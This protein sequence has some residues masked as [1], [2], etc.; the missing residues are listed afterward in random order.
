MHRGKIIYFAPNS[1][2]ETFSL[3]NRYG[4]SARI[5]GGGTALF[6]LINRGLLEDVKCLVDLNNLGFK[7][8]H[9]SNDSL[10]IGAYVTMSEL[11]E[12][13]KNANV[14]GLDVLIDCIDVIRPIQ[15]RN[16]ATIGGAVCSAIPF[17]DLPVAL[18]S[19]DAVLKIVSNN[20]IKECDLNTFYRGPFE[21]ILKEDEIVSEITIKMTKGI[22]SS[23]FKKFALTGNDYALVSCGVYLKSDVK[24][25]IQE[26]RIVVGGMVKMPSRIRDL[27]K[28]FQGRN[29]NEI[30]ANTEIKEKIL[31]SLKNQEWDTGYRA[32][33]EYTIEIASKIIYDCIKTCSIRL[34]KR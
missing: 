15:V 19:L 21:T 23:A 3:L 11:K 5:I 12:Y 2:D 27:E 24:L 9:I 29:I 25:N 8:I 1:L 4:K 33:V 7:N 20:K 31:E 16:V 17:L 22:F 13:I 26:I 18:L 10:K 32:S 34:N 14:Q 30:L 28:F 6:E